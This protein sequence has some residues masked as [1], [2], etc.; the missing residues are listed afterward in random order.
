M[1]H[2]HGKSKG[3]V[4]LA[5][6]ILSNSIFTDIKGNLPIQSEDESFDEEILTNI[7]SLFLDLNQIGVGPSKLFSI[8]HDTVWS[9]FSDD[10][11]LLNAVKDYI[12]IKVKLKFDPPSSSF[13]Q[14][15]YNEIANKLEWRLNFYIEDKIAKEN[16][17]G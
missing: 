5:T 2:A 9:E 4:S 16:N 8:D 17:H 1:I 7:N 12:V 6:N 14:S 10:I 15:S 13:V 11:G 3:G